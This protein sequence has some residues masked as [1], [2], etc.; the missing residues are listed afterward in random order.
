MDSSDGGLNSAP[1]SLLVVSSVVRFQHTDPRWC[2]GM[3][4][5][6]AS[7]E[8]FLKR[9]ISL[10]QPPACGLLDCKSA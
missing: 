1:G 9:I 2:S 6:Y 5:G 10:G 4:L 7:V 3:R 8:P